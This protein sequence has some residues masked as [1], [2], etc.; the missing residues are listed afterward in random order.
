MAPH[1]LHQHA[2]HAAPA[3]PTAAAPP[4]RFADGPIPSHQ[5]FSRRTNL[6]RL[7][8][9]LAW[10][11]LFR[12]SPRPLH[13]W[14][15]MLLRLFGAK[16]HPTARVY[17]TTRIWA[18]WNLEMHEHSC[19]GDNCDIY[20]VDRITIGPRSTVSQYSYLCTASHDFEDPAHP[21]TTAPIT[22]GANVWVAVDVFVGPGVTIA[23]GTVV[24]ARSSVFKSLP[25]WVLAVGTPARPVRPRV[26]RDSKNQPGTEGGGGA[27]EGSGGGAGG[28]NP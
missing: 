13:A 21:L 25:A 10:R 26:F 16:L 8:W 19:I 24:G 14:R 18:P 4:A 3:A 2:P 28:G 20:C 9:A 6:G 5:R 15:N 1:A 17:S 12:P 11:L 22:L 7:L 27:G 23:D